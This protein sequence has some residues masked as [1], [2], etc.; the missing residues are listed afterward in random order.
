LRTGLL[1]QQTL[2][3]LEDEGELATRGAAWKAPEPRSSG[4]W[5]YMFPASCGAGRIRAVTL[6]TSPRP[7][8]KRRVS[9]TFSERYLG[10]TQ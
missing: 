1:R 9:R 5:G 2:D 10:M 7:L 3:M 6:T 4:G 8:G